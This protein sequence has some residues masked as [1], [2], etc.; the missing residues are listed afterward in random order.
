MT[1]ISCLGLIKSYQRSIWL[2][3]IVIYLGNGLGGFRVDDLPSSVKLQ[4][5]N[6][7]P[8]TVDRCR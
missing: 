1:L 3:C 5:A 7:V 4:K 8:L 2:F 6:R